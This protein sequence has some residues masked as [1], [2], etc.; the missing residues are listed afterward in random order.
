MHGVFKSARCKVQGARGDT[1]GGDLHGG[2]DDQ[3][4]SIAKGKGWKGKSGMEIIDPHKVT[5]HG[6]F[7]FSFS[8]SSFL[9]TND[10]HT[11]QGRPFVCMYSTLRSYDMILI[12]R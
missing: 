4:N 9:L 1:S 8:S 7:F 11:S 6:L 5:L 2:F 3:F 12:F 10:L